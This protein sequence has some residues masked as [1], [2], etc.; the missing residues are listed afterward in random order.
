MCCASTGQINRMRV[1]PVTFIS[2][3]VRTGAMVFV[4]DIGGM[5]NVEVINVIGK[6]LKEMEERKKFEFSREKSKYMMVK[7]GKKNCEEEPEVELRQGRMQK[8]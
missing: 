5:G 7:T 2:T 6:N 8:T 3:E 1:K 4:D